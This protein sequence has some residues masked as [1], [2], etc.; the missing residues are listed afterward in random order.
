MRLFITVSFQWSFSL[1]AWE[2]PFSPPL[3]IIFFLPAF[4]QHALSLRCPSK[5]AKR[6]IDFTEEQAEL[7]PVSSV[8]VLG[9]LNNS[10][11][12]CIHYIPAIEP[13][14]CSLHISNENGTKKFNKNEPLH[15]MV[16]VNINTHGKM[17]QLVVYLIQRIFVLEFETMCMLSFFFWC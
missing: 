13:W 2:P 9:Y 8:N 7:T 10:K 16:P 12:E 15:D 3:S 1:P 4:S 11:K 5:Q 14:S 6:H 17:I